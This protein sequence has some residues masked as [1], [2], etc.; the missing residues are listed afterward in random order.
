MCILTREEWPRL[1]VLTHGKQSDDLHYYFSILTTICII[2][3][4]G[5]M[6]LQATFT[7]TCDSL[8]ALGFSLGDNK[9]N[10]AEY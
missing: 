9:L 1:K 6:N 3:T 2:R 8:A 5:L 4:P 7:D 10:E